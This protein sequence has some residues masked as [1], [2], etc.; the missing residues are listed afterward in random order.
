[1]PTLQMLDLPAA[2]PLNVDIYTYYLLCFSREPW[3]IEVWSE[4]KSFIDFEYGE[5]GVLQSLGLYQSTK[6][7]QK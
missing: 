2:I 4:V 1:M 3:L 5:Y 6:H 7:N